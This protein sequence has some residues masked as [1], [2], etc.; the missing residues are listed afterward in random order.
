LV[1]AHPDF[2]AGGVATTFVGGLDLAALPPYV[3]EASSPSPDAA[4][5]SALEGGERYLVEVNGKQFS[6]KVAAEGGRA[7]GSKQSARRQR[8]GEVDGAVVSPMH[9]VVLRVAVEA[10]QRV[11]SGDLLLT[12]EAMKM[13][14]EVLAPRAGTVLSIGAVAGAT[15]DVGTLLAVVE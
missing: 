7:R 6:V 15:V 3:P 9:G 12:I 11:E 13:E 14:N 2:V 5:P 1:L 4:A 10:G 8:S